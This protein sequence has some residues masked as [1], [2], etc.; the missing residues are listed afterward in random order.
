MY[1][2][3]GEEVQGDSFLQCC[4][5]QPARKETSEFSTEEVN[6]KVKKRVPCLCLAS[7]IQARIAR[8]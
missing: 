4:L 3:A 2:L 8:M 7:L 1:R 6:T 5:R